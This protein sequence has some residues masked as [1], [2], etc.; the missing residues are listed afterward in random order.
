[1]TTVSASV[2]R[3]TLPAQIDYVQ[4]GGRVAITRHGQVVAFLVHPD[5]LAH[6]RAVEAWDAADRLEETL[7]EARVAP[8]PAPVIDAVRAEELAGAVR[9]GRDR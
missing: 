9:A 7:A 5:L 8:V 1:M 3:Q 2:A 6:H 4:A